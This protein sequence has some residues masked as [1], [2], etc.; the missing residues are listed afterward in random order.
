MKLR[1]LIDEHNYY[2]I[3]FYQKF[4]LFKNMLELDNI[5]DLI[6]FSTSNPNEFEEIFSQIPE[7]CRLSELLLSSKLS[8]RTLKFITTC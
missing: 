2:N 4:L 7:S 8:N 5:D 3:K 1:E 6:V